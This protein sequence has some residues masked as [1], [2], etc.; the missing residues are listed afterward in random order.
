M[1]YSE[2]AGLYGRLESTPKTLE[3]TALLAEF[4]AKTPSAVLG[5]VVLLSQGRVFPPHSDKEIGIASKLVEKAILR[6]SGAPKAKF[7]EAMKKTGDHGLTARELL[8]FKR[9]QTLASATLDTAGVHSELKRLAEISGAK[10]VDRKMAVVSKLLSSASPAE[11]CYI[12]RTIL[13]TLRIGVGEGIVR[14][15]IAKAFE[16]SPQAVQ[17]SY[18]ILNDFS[19]VSKIAKSS[20]EPGLLKS[21]L[22]PGRA[23]KVMLAQKADG[24]KDAVQRIGKAQYEYKF[25]GAR[26]QIHIVDKKITV[27]TRRLED[28][29]KQFPDIVKMVS[30]GV[31]AKNAII[32]GEAVATD[33]KTGKALPFQMLSK[34]IKRKYDIDEVAKS[35]PVTLHLFDLLYLDGKNYLSEPLKRRREALE[36]IVSQSDRLRL[37][38]KIVS[39]NEKEI[40]K[41]YDAALKDR[42]EGIMAKNLDAGYKPGSRVGYMLKIKPT[43]ENL[44]LVVIGA[45][46]GEG[47]RTSWFGSFYLACRDAQTGEFLEIGKM[48]TGLSDDQFR[49]LTALLKPLAISEKGQ[50]IEIKPEVVFEIAYEEIQKSPTYSSGYA[51]RFPRL[52]CLRDDRKPEDC[53]DLSYI[54]QLYL[55]QK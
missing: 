30:H 5:S 15:A 39:D 27:Y 51:L 16:V 4:L 32:E 48:A 13:G 31:K 21:K 53:S 40:Q 52:V 33:P 9:Q 29:T 8:K 50:K 24:I 22:E 2:L 26:T 7:D 54:D 42:Q 37:S 12:V 34:R 28:V 17:H 35:H 43:M 47:R 6:V 49:E 41:F 45:D 11:A 38:T 1:R 19:E 20:G 3:K 10:S 36:K 46:W 14:D 55:G 44:D 23:L 25:D 18:D